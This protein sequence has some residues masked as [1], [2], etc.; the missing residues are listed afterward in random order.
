MGVVYKAWDE[1]L[2]IPVALKLIRPEAMS[3]PDAA[4]Q[5]ERRFK[6]ELVL[7]RQVTHKNVVRIHDLGDLEK[8]KYFTMPFIEG[9]D[10]GKVIG[11]DGRLPVARA[12]H[13]ARQV[14]AGLAAAHEVGIVHRH[15]KPENVMLV[16]DDTAIIM[17]FALTLTHIIHHY[18]HASP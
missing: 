17:V 8:F 10:L 4:L 9:Q 18:V 2:S 15:L 3:D 7:A 1:E 16:A 5:M 12:L 6:R 13:I 11:R 14:A